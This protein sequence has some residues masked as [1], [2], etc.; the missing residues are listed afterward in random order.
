M[1][2]SMENTGTFQTISDGIFC[3]NMGYPG[4]H[5]DIYHY[6]QSPRMLPG[7]IWSNITG[8]IFNNS[9]W[10]GSYS[11]EDL[12]TPSCYLG[13]I[14]A[15]FVLS[16][17]SLGLFRRKESSLE[18]NSSKTSEGSVPKRSQTRALKLM[19]VTAAVSSKAP[20]LN[21]GTSHQRTESDSH[22][23]NYSNSD[24]SL[25]SDCE[26]NELSNNT[27]NG[28]DS[29]SRRNFEKNLI[30]WLSRLSLL[31]LL[32]A[33]G[34][35]GLF[36]FLRAF[37]VLCGNG[38][39]LTFKDGDPVGGIYWM[40]TVLLPG[41]ATFRFPAKMMIFFLF[42]TSFLAALGF[43]RQLNS[44]RLKKIGGII[45]FLS[46]VILIIA[47][48]CEVRQL[49]GIS[50][51]EKLP[52]DLNPNAVKIM[53]YGAACQ[54]LLFLSVFFTLRYFLMKNPKGKPF[55]VFLILL[56]GTLDLLYSNLD[57]V[58]TRSKINLTQKSNVA[59]KIFQNRKESGN[60]Y[61]PR[62][63]YKKSWI[64]DR[65]AAF[66]VN[67]VL[68]EELKTE[69]QQRALI[70]KFIFLE[71]LGALQ[72]IAST[73]A[74]DGMIQIFTSL[75][76]LNSG[77]ETYRP[78]IKKVLN[79]LDVEYS[80]DETSDF[81]LPE[82]ITLYGFKKSK[83]MSKDDWEHYFNRLVEEGW[84]LDTVLRKNPEHSGRIHII[85][86]DQLSKSAKPL[87]RLLE[88]LQI[89]DEILPGE[90]AK[91]TRFENE[92]IEMEILLKEPGKIIL[93][94]QFHPEWRAEAIA[95]DT[96]KNSA[97]SDSSFRSVSGKRIPLKIV[98]F[99]EL[100]RQFELPAGS[101]YI[102]M[103]FCPISFYWGAGISLAVW[104]L[105]AVIWLICGL[106]SFRSAKLGQR[107]KFHG[108]S[109][110]NH[111]KFKI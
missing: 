43:D 46:L 26:N 66:N 90:T 82:M 89:K 38:Q 74:S 39:N 21:R 81:D 32:A 27:E 84:P 25:E 36:W 4:H 5:Q 60:P 62:V 51:Q 77:N 92:K 47:S 15:I 67:P 31:A 58:P 100:M 55:F 22:L 103:T 79:S 104:I 3:R 72:H 44:S 85:R 50:P 20:S 10:I 56:F 52:A 110:V 33:L 9:N 40:M 96:G 71:N 101:W 91:I 61:P 19:P 86:S 24:F 99:R 69:W 70:P 80:L 23:K 106:Q 37:G 65:I 14:P 48:F 45:A 88:D 49:A 53:I 111:E 29:L 76:I 108:S 17:F 6:S 107:E 42:G 28:E 98:K 30:V 34:G 105:I 94:E 16:I 97:G 2:R 68:R 64:P 18:K 1:P 78:Y 75:D 41:F 54:T 87:E 83:E 95:A 13:I 35:F 8:H 102:K 63:Y 57:Y 11:N 73:S 12:W 109:T 59:E 93:C 7:L